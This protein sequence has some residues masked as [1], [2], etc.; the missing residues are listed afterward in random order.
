MQYVANL[1]STSTDW[2]QLSQMTGDFMDFNKHTREA[3]AA[4]NIIVTATTLIVKGQLE[5]MFGF[6]DAARETYIELES[7][8]RVVRSTYGFNLVCWG[9]GIANYEC[10]RTSGKRRYLRK[11]RTYKKHLERGDVLGPN[12]STYLRHLELK[13]ALLQRE[14]DSLASSS[15]GE[16]LPFLDRKLEGFALD[17]KTCTPCFAVA[18][19][20]VDAGSSAE[21]LGHYAASKRYFE[22]A[23]TLFYEEWGAV[24]PGAWVE[25]KCETLRRKKE[26]EMTAFGTRNFLVG[27]IVQFSDDEA[28]E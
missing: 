26:Q 10:F 11:A 8:G 12:A 5:N 21:R 27:G 4:K 25:E 6:H 20:F 14:K 13:E 28:G 16:A 15:D 2:H 19:A 23:K 17:G 9:A 3:N 24:A 22:Q 1:R 18:A 7:L